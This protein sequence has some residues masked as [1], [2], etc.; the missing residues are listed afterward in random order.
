MAISLAN[1]R[2]EFRPMLFLAAPLVLAEL[3]W[4]AMGVVDTIMAGRLGPAALGAGCLG[5]NLFYPIAIFGTG[6]LLGMDT[7][8]AQSFGADDPRDCRRTLVNGVW[9]AAGLAAPLALVIWA[10]IPL[11]RA[12]GT[13]PHVMVLLGPYLE[14]LLWGIL[15]LLA[16]TAFR[17]YL[18]AVNVVKP[19]TFALVSA[20]IVNFAGNWSLMFGHWG[21]PA[22]GLEGSGWSTTIARAYMAA[23]L[24]AAIAWHERKSG[25]LLFRMSWRPDFAR[26]RRLLDLGLPAA[27]QILIEGGLF[28]VVAVLAARLDEVSLAAHGIAVNVVATTYMVPLGISSAAAVRVGQAVGRKDRPGVATS[29]WTA[30]LLGTLFM[31]AAGLALW[32]APRWIIRIFSRD[33]AV[34]ASGA[35]LLR[36]AALFELF[37]GFQTVT[38]GAL[39]GLGD[40]RSPMLAHLAGYWAIGLPVSYVLCFPLGWGVTGIWVGLTAALIPIGLALV[41]V[42]KERVR[43]LTA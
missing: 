32:T 9:L 36:I 24:L 38:T 42:W 8:V 7:L 2:R 12:V 15:P 28:G 40:T 22:M 26:L 41:W 27:L 10:L 35:A 17:R 43:S 11:L 6:L 13:N 18:Q 29:G 31:G 3:G 19:I 20:N 4:M 5:G 23:V 34:I 21:A 14:A 1:L 30:L 39:R 16:Y 33:A 37:D 25:N